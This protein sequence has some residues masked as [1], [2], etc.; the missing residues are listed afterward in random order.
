MSPSNDLLNGSVVFLD[1]G[2]QN[3]F[4]RTQSWLFVNVILFLVNPF[5]RL[6]ASINVLWQFFFTSEKSVPEHSLK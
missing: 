5:K 4:N 3:H 6:T 2:E 1:L